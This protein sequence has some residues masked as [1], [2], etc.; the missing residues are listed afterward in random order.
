VYANLESAK[1]TGKETRMREIIQ[2]E[3]LWDPR[4]LFTQ[5][6]RSGNQVFIAGQ[7]SVD[8]DGKT[9]GDGDIQAQTRQVFAN[10]EKALR[11]VGAT[12]QD[13]VKLTV[14]S[15]DLDAHLPTITE[16]RSRHFAEPV[17]STTLQISRLV[18]PEWLLEIEAAVVLP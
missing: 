3:G 6:A 13:V 4:P 12:F 1:R 5:V 18:R 7:T 14:Y 11:S 15:T 17:P 16:Y 2:P 8:Q 9:V 10:L